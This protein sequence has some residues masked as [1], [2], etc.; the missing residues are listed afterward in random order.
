MVTVIFNAPCLYVQ[1][2]FVILALADRIFVDL[3]DLITTIINLICAFQ[4]LYP[5]LRK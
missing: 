1:I 5:N 4:M 3:M 2:L